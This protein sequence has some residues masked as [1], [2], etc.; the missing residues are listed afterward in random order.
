MSTRRIKPELVRDLP[1]SPVGYPDTPRSDPWFSAARA[2]IGLRDFQL[3]CGPDSSSRD[4]FMP[5]TRL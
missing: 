3:A 1:E 4:D 2:D 5:S